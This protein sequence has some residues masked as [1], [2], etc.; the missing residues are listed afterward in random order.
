MRRN[1][2]LIGAL[3]AIITF[4]TLSAF[5]HRPWGR[6]GPGHGRWRNDNCYYHGHDRHL[7]DNDKKQ[8]INKV[9][10]TDSTTY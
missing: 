6:Y 2:F 9:P 1:N 4:V 5:V 8:D 3:V 10:L 7:G